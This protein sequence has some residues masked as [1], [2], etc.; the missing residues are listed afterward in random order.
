MSNGG[1]SVQL[2]SFSHVKGQTMSSHDGKAF[3]NGSTW[4][5]CGLCFD[6]VKELILIYVSVLT[7]WLVWGQCRYI[8]ISVSM[9]HVIFRQE[10]WTGSLR[11]RQVHVHWKRWKEE[12]KNHSGATEAAQIIIAVV[13]RRFGLDESTPDM[14]SQLSMLRWTIIDMITDSKNT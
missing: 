13:M 5:Y 14:A 8:Q 9:L 1:T 3:L 7:D 4:L 11:C 6:S 2:A 10:Y 12:E